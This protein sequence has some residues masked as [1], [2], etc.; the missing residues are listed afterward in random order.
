[1]GKGSGGDGGIRTRDTFL[2]YAHL[3]NECLQ[4]LGHVS[5]V[6]A[7][8]GK[9]AKVHIYQRRPA[10]FLRSLGESLVISLRTSV[11]AKQETHALVLIY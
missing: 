6:E 10:P 11:A 5:V 4:P 7:I 3:A 1:M 8:N 9:A 2:G